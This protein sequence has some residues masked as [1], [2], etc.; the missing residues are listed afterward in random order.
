[1]KSN[2]LEKILQSQEMKN[3]KEYMNLNENSNPLPVNQESNIY[4]II[5]SNN[6]FIEV[7][8]NLVITLVVL[9]VTIIALLMVTLFLKYWP[10]NCKCSKK[11]HSS[12]TI[13][14][15]LPISH[16]ANNQN[17]CT[18]SLELARPTAPPP[19]A[20][21]NNRQTQHQNQTLRSAQFIQVLGT[22]SVLTED[23]E[24]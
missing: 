20:P 17:R 21:S 14:N 24:A 1:M 22:N 7:Q 6:S 8:F 11:L 19:P 5:N 4:P 13:Y 15:M 10:D 9:S 18:G 23:D 3:V 2:L 16:P 12:Y